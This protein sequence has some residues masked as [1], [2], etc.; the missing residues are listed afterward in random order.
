MSMPHLTL[1]VPQRLKTHIDA[2]V[3]EGFESAESYL[4][5]LL[6]ADQLDENRAHDLISGLSTDAQDKLDGLLA[7]RMEGPFVRLEAGWEDRVMEKALERV[8][9]K[10]V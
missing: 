7:E 10:I 4:L 1:N 6:E 2:K 9:A 3:H 5:S 8:A